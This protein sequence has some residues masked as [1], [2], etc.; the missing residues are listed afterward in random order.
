MAARIN[1][2]PEEKRER[3]RQ[4]QRDWRAHHPGYCQRYAEKK[5]ERAKAQKQQGGQAEALELE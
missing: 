2:T 3:H 1:L 5:I 4:Q